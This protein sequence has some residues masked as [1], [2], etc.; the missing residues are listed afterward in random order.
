MHTTL[1]Q[2][3]QQP[4]YTGY[5]QVVGP[6]FP[7][8]ARLKDSKRTNSFFLFMFFKMRFLTIGVHL[9]F[10]AYITNPYFGFGEFGG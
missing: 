4:L 9:K 5:I 7:A 1:Q 10:S 2:T 8:G 6:P 3:L